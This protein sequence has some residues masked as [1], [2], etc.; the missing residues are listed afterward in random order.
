MKNLTTPPFGHP[1][2]KV[3]GNV[4]AFCLL[5][6]CLLPFAV[7]A[8]KIAV[9]SPEGVTTV[10]CNLDSAILEAPAGS[11]LYLSAG[12]FQVSNASRITKKLNIIGVGHRPD[13]P[14]GNT[15]IS[16]NL[17]FEAGSDNSAVMG[18]YL[19]GDIRLANISSSVNNFLLRFCNV[20]SVQVYK[21]NCQ[22]VLINQNY[23]RNN[24]SCSLSPITF[25]NNVLHSISF[26]QCVIIQNNIIRHYNRH[27][28][29]Y[30]YNY[31]FYDLIS[32]QIINNILLDPQSIHQGANVIVSN[33][34]LGP[35]WG[36]NCIQVTN[37]AN[38]FEGPDDGVSPTSNFH[39]KD[40]PW[41]TGAT[42]GGEVGIYGGTGFSDTAL[43]PGPR[44]ISK[45]IAD[46]TDA[47]G[48]LKV[49]IEVGAE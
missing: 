27:C 5:L 46:Q 6:S 2:N 28:P 12:G 30:C 33:N 39:L 42:D 17:H 45:K 11:T 47:E 23:I 1:F 48:K 35:N 10:Y 8:Q 31:A 49:E 29:N 4:M 9:V 24:S 19:G 32:S 18:I 13:T 14:E 44:I 41:K 3:K 26:V 15:N 21:A 34:A 36:N 38:V 43:P 37:W 16:G 40:G 22:G 25:S 7:Q 20:N